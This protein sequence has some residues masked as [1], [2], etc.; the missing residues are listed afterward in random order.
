M[1]TLEKLRAA[2]V[3]RNVD[4]DKLFNVPEF[5]GSAVLST[6]TI[7]WSGVPELRITLAANTEFDASNLI[8]GKTI[9]LEISG[10]YT[11]TFAA[12]FV[13]VDGSPAPDPAEVNY[14]TMRCI[15]AD[16]GNERIIYSVNFLNV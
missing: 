11:A 6:N 4:W 7:D 16:V 5:Q 10:A 14:I 2:M 8:A 3:A 9:G 1:D 13:K 15:R 12:K